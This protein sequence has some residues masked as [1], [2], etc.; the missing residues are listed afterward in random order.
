MA[1]ILILNW[2]VSAECVAYLIG[3]QTV[4]NRNRASADTR[5]K[6]SWPRASVLFI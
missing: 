2:K 1:D 3:L 6:R 4:Q 5:R